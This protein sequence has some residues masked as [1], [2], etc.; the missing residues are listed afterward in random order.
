MEEVKRR[1]RGR[2]STKEEEEEKWK[3]EK[4]E[5]ET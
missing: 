4:A 3:V 5:E 2:E 1:E